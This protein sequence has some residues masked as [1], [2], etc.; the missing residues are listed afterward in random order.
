MQTTPKQP[1][2]QYISVAFRKGGRAYTYHYTGLPVQVG[3]EVQVQS[4]DGMRT[5]KVL[6]VSEQAPAFATKAVVR[7]LPQKA[8]AAAPLI[9]DGG[10]P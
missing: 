8:D 6:K 7:V 10:K 1:N 2:R 9:D 4:R 5:L 3:D